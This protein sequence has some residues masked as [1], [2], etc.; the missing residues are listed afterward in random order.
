VGKLYARFIQAE[1]GTLIGSTALQ[2]FTGPVENLELSIKTRAA[3]TLGERQ[4]TSDG[5]RKREVYIQEYDSTI[6]KLE[7]FAV[8]LLKVR[9]WREIFK[10]I[11]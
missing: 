4:R 10:I 5:T 8:A 7:Q 1:A 6:Q 9:S 2:T 11:R 3:V